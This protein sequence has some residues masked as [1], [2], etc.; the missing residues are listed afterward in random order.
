M[1]TPW[2][3]ETRD[4]YKQMA[5]ASYVE[6]RH[7]HELGEAAMALLGL[8]GVTLEQLEAVMQATDAGVDS[9]ETLQRLQEGS[10]DGVV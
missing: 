6:I 2:G 5:V 4:G 8:L 9:L 10:T 3:Y 1:K 7:R